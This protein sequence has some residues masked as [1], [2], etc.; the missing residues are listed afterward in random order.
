MCEIISEVL[1]WET[2]GIRIKRR[3]IINLLVCCHFLLC[4]CM[5]VTTKLAVTFFSHYILAMRWNC[6]KNVFGGWILLNREQYKCR[7]VNPYMAKCGKQQKKDMWKLVLSIQHCA[8][9]RFLPICNIAWENYNALL[10]FTLCAIGVPTES[11]HFGSSMARLSTVRHG[12]ILG[13]IHIWGQWS[14]F[15]RTWFVGP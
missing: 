2:R 1:V 13:G 14:S 3:S 4:V 6:V 15:N 8:C 10:S 9:T 11:S 5:C 7:R 12:S